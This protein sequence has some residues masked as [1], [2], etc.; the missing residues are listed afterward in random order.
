MHVGDGDA[1]FFFFNV[2]AHLVVHLVEE[3]DL[4]SSVHTRWMYCI[5]RMNKVLKV[6]CSA[7]C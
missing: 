6:M 3:L 5:K 2:M 7:F 4:C 1:P